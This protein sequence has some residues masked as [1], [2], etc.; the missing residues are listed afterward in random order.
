MSS[1]NHK[2]DTRIYYLAI[3]ASPLYNQSLRSRELPLWSLWII[4]C[5]R[6][7]VNDTPVCHLE[8]SCVLYLFIHLAFKK[9]LSRVRASA[10][11]WEEERIG[12][13]EGNEWDKTLVFKEIN[14]CSQLWLLKRCVSRMLGEIT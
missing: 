13:G 10:K 11:Y 14:D 8:S 7:L 12:G 4:G 2:K 3:L 9:I 1:F 5:K 6:V